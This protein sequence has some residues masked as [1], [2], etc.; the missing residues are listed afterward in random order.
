MHNNNDTRCLVIDAFCNENWLCNRSKCVIYSFLNLR[1]IDAFRS[2][3]FRS[4]FNCY[5][6]KVSVEALALEVFLINTSAEH[7]I[8]KRVFFVP[9]FLFFNWKKRKRKNPF[10]LPFAFQP[11]FRELFHFRSSDA[12]DKINDVKTMFVRK[13]GNPPNQ[14]EFSTKSLNVA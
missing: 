4:F 7:L 2:A 5:I 14:S 8:E 11:Y 6:V 10:L 13:T 3:F 12:I 9:K 1:L